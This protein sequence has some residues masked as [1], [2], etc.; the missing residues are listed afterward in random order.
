MGTDEP[1]CFLFYT[2]GSGGVDVGDGFLQARRAMGTDEPPCF[3]FILMGQAVSTLATAFYKPEGPWEPMMPYRRL[4]K[5]GLEAHAPVFVK[6]NS[7]VYPPSPSV[8][9][10]THLDPWLC[11]S[12]KTTLRGSFLSLRLC[13]Q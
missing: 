3:L 8:K 2:H 13:L 12:A 1:P 9:S 10:V 11:T 5:P 4:C 6:E 7:A